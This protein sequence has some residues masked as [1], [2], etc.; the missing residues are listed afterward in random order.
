MTSVQRHVQHAQAT[1]RDVIQA[2]LVRPSTP[3]FRILNTFAVNPS[4][5][6]L[7]E[8]ELDD[9][10]EDVISPAKLRH[11]SGCS[12]LEQVLTLDLTVDTTERSLGSLGALLPNL[13]EL[14]LSG[15]LITSVRDLGTT[16]RCLR[17]LWMSR[18]GLQDLDG[19]SSIGPIRELYLSYNE[20]SD[21]SPLSMV[22]TLELVDIESNN[23]K[24]ME[25]VEFLSMCPNL[26]ALNIEG[27]PVTCTMNEGEQ[28]EKVHALIPQLEYLDD[29]PVK[30]GCKELSTTSHK[31]LGNTGYLN[32]EMRVV[33]SSLKESLSEVHN[34][35]NTAGSTRVEYVLSPSPA[36]T[37][38]LA[39]DR[40]GSGLTQGSAHCGPASK[41]KS[42]FTKT[43][44]ENL[45]SEMTERTPP[46]TLVGAWS[47]QPD[48]M[49]KE[50]NESRDWLTR[51]LTQDSIN[52]KN[53]A[54]EKRADYEAA[55]RETSRPSSSRLSNISTEV[56]HN[57]EKE[58]PRDSGKSRDPGKSHDRTATRAPEKADESRIPLY[59]ESVDVMKTRR[60]R[61]VSK[62]RDKS[63]DRSRDKSVDR[64]RDRSREPFDLSKPQGMKDRSIDS[65]NIRSSGKAWAYKSNSSTTEYLK[66]RT[67]ERSTKKSDPGL[68]SKRGVPVRAVYRPADVT[69]SPS[70]ELRTLPSPPGGGGPGRSRRLRVSIEDQVAQQATAD[71]LFSERMPK[72]GLSRHNN[73]PPSF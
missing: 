22:D 36:P 26:T 21:I 43:V 56:L 27:N 39:A 23:V 14:R 42:K 58:K 54:G 5:T 24:T 13:R 50:W 17:V 53:N 15:S 7:V 44:K 41:L 52:E 10:F 51:E 32:S 60:R 19:I 69:N 67:A 40:G 35:P 1:S 4:P 18:C 70:S 57:L 12:D 38:S 16:L 9:T 55:L 73:A 47:D 61:L 37:E 6:F 31:L 49:I 34:R 28:R 11:L 62:P 45:Y 8:E 33:S 30:G 59:D 64:P 63:V 20:I 68:G 66:R 29:M 72:P 46:P 25:Q 65:T 71:V 48:D 3:S 2:D